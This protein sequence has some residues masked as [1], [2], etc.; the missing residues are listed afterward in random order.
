MR[1]ASVCILVLLSSC[2]SFNDG[3][4]N[5]IRK[6][7]NDTLVN[8]HDNGQIRSK[9]RS[10]DNRKQGY[11]EFYFENG[12]LGA[13]G[14][15][16]ND[17]KEGRWYYFEED[18]NQVIEEITWTVYQDQL[19]TKLNVPKDWIF[20]SATENFD[21]AYSKNDFPSFASNFSL[22]RIIIEN[23]FAS[24]T[25]KKIKGVIEEMNTDNVKVNVLDKR[26]AQINGL[27][28]KWAKFSIVMVK[29]E[30]VMLQVFISSKKDEVHLLTFASQKNNFDTNLRMYNEI[31]SSIKIDR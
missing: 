13:K 11:W 10:I 24:F 9:G 23:N 29:F 15:F 5:L 4:D 12:N 26:E 30:V 19:G 3:G 27:D 7:E 28:S 20:H 6:L 17:L 22:N 8:L 2:N 1:I 25:E 21:V 18:S 14:N 31:I 16:L